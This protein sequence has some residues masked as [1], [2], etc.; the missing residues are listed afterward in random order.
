M[1]SIFSQMFP[2][3][4]IVK[5]GVS[6]LRE[7][8][9]SLI[10]TD[11]EKSNDAK[12]ERSEARTMLVE[13]MKATQGQNIARR[14]IALMVTFIWLSLH[15]FSA[16]LAFVAG[17]VASSEPWLVSSELI[18]ETAIELND[19]AM[20]IIAFYFAAPYMGQMINGILNR[21][22]PGIKNGS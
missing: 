18:S 1:F 6:T 7:G 11:E 14:V 19:P 8:L 17:W 13:W 22:K 10:Y 5:E 16:G 21:K 12:K 9:D 20:L 2:T 15:L 4:K 3:S